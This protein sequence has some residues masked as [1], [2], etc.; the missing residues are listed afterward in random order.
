LT[1]ATVI[2]TASPSSVPESGAEVTFTFTVNN[3]GEEEVTL[4]SLSDPFFGGSLD[5]QG[6]CAVGGA[7]PAGGSYTCSLTEWLESPTLADHTNTVTADLDDNHGRTVSAS[8]SA[9]VMFTDVTVFIDLIK[10]ASPGSVPETGA[11]VTFDFVVENMRDE[12]ITLRSLTDNAFGDLNGEGTCA[13]GGTISAKGNYACS[14]TRFVSGIGQSQ[15]TNRAI[16]VADDNDG[17]TDAADDTATVVF[18][19]SAASLHIYAP[20]ME[21]DLNVTGSGQPGQT[22]TL[23]DLQDGSWSLSEQVDGG[24]TFLFDVSGVLPTGLVGGHV[25]V[26]EGYGREDWALVQM[27]ATPVP[28]PTPTPAPMDISLDPECG[29][30]G[31]NPLT[32]YGYDW[33]VTDVR[34]DH[35]FEGVTTTLITLDWDAHETYF[36]IGV[37]TITD[38]TTGTHTI[39]SYEH[40]GGNWEPQDSEP[41]T[42]PCAPGPGYPNLVVES[43]T[44]SPTQPISTY[45]PIAFTVAI[46]N[47]GVTTATHVFWADMYLDPAEPI[48]PTSPSLPSGRDYTAIGPLGP[49]ESTMVVLGLPGGLSVAGVHTASVMADTWHQVSESDEVDNLSEPVTVTIVARPVI[50][51]LTPT[52]T[53]LPG[54]KGSIGGSTWLYYEGD[55]APQGRVL[56]SVY[57][58]TGEVVAEG[59]SDRSGQ[60]LLEDIPAGTFNMFAELYVDGEF[61]LDIL[62]N[63]EVKNNQLTPY[64]TLLLH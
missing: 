15:H 12:A 36:T 58:G 6:T 32:V 26:V 31:D 52:P 40:V 54:G 7:I 56:V 35:V 50:P 17:N 25:M 18:T 8:D 46:A 3:T 43:V 24:G 33:P 4:T 1:E 51:G 34:I 2:K 44:V 29:P 42:V 63:V 23:R 64:Q 37:L 38:A 30:V 39:Q 55:L 48:S 19:L 49:G 27:L 53:P 60:Y 20:L 22:V 5:G 16:A 57:T 45:V 9:M 61:F 14:V 21:G 47:T 13:T 11:N 28:T 59:Y 62:T 10:T 41:F